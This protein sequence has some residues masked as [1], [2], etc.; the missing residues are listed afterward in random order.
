M[1]VQGAAGSAWYAND[2]YRKKRFR[3][4][5]IIA[6]IWVSVYGRKFR[7]DGIH[8]KATELFTGNGISGGFDIS[9]SIG[10]TNVLPNGSCNGYNKMLLGFSISIGILNT[11]SR[12]VQLRG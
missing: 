5:S 1:V 12:L 10:Y 3:A 7:G 2:V 11:A 4:G 8:T 6:T 9:L